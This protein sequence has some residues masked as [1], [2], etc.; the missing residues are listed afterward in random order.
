MSSEST[1][2]V[3]DF[4]PQPNRIVEFPS[5]NKYPALWLD[6][7][8]IDDLNSMITEEQAASAGLDAFTV[9]RR[10]IKKLVPSVEDG[11]LD[12]LTVRQLP[13]LAG[14]LKRF[15]KDAESDRPL[16]SAPTP[17]VPEVSSQP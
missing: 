8:T 3:R 10:H 5:G 17:S 16:E 12:S 1:I 11:D 14:Q 9:L 13:L 15:E 6:D 7:V 4:V 2:D